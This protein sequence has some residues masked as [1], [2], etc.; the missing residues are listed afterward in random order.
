MLG[1]PFT[2]MVSYADESAPAE[3]SP[4]KQAE[5]TAEKKVQE[6]LKTLNGRL[7]LWI[8]GADTLI[9]VNNK[10][11]GKPVDR[12]DARHMLQSLSG[13][14]HQVITAMALYVGREKRIA[15]SS[16]SSQV[17]FAPLSK[18]ELEWYLETGEWQGVAGAYQIQG[19]ASCFIS[20]IE[21]SYSGI[22]GLPIH[23]FYGML[24]KNGYPY[25][26]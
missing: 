9:F 20:H 1:L 5:Y 4:Q 17:H 22:V 24:R 25:G 19:L 21:G 26:A 15:I 18:S 14:I 8:F 13:T 11:F 16:V 2:I 7:P 3:L 23:E 10:I 12:E 6:I